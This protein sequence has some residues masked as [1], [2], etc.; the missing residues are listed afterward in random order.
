MIKIATDAAKVFTVKS[1]AVRALRAFAAK[2]PGLAD[3]LAAVT[4]EGGFVI[5]CGP[6]S[7]AGDS[8]R[9]LVKGAGFE[10][11]EG[12]ADLPVP[13]EPTVE[14]KTEVVAGALGVE[15]P[16][17]ALRPAQAPIEGMPVGLLVQGYVPPSRGLCETK[18]E[19]LLAAREIYGAGTKVGDD[20]VCKK[21]AR[22]E[23]YWGP[24]EAPAPK[25][26]APK[27]APRAAVAPTGKRAEVL[28]SVERGELPPVPD[29]SAEVH[30]RNRARLAQ[31]VAMAEAGDVAGLEAFSIKPNCTS[32][33]AMDRY[34]NLAVT[35]LKARAA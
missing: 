6:F 13:V 24:V 34:R 14:A 28:M 23:W 21:T 8:L 17:E 35:A 33:K 12:A 25:V 22:G 2:N 29:F 3:A 20:F 10:L 16:A 32:P 19:A 31:L 7:E 30:K 4:T 26:E 11:V 27:A 1:N 18:G 15:A 5:Q 9:A